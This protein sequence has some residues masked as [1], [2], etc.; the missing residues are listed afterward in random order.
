MF[1]KPET[2]TV[3]KTLSGMDRLRQ[4]DAHR[5]RRLHRFAVQLYD[6]LVERYGIHHEQTKLALRLVE[7]TNPDGR[8]VVVPVSNRASA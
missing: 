2:G 4:D 1:T 7:S 8:S 6:T 5:Q 3:P